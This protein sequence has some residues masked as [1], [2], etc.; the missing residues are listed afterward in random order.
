MDPVLSVLV[1]P[2]HTLY[3]ANSGGAHNQLALLTAMQHKHKIKL[4]LT[5]DNVAEQD[6]DRLREILCH[7]QF[8]QIGYRKQNRLKRLKYS[9]LKKRRKY[10]NL[11]K[12]LLHNDS[13]INRFLIKE[14]SIIYQMAEVIRKEQADVIQIDHTK[15]L[16]LVSHLPGTCKIMYVHHELY[17]TRVYQELTM[18][19]HCPDYAKQIANAVRANELH[20]LRAC[21][22]VVTF[23]ESDKDILQK[24]GLS[25]PVHV[26]KPFCLPGRTAN[27][28]DADGLPKLIF[29]GGEEH[30]PNKEGLAWF[31]EEVYPL[32]SA[33]GKQTEIW[34]TGEWSAPFQKKYQYLPLQ[35]LGFVP[36]LEKVM[37]N[38][39]SLSP[40]R[41]G[42]GVRIKICT[43]IAKGLPVVS[44]TLGASG[45]NGLVNGLNILIADTAEEFAAGI[46]QL[47]EQRDLRK[48]L[49]E[50][51]YALGERLFNGEEFV[52]TRMSFL[53]QIATS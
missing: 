22:G 18:K 23:A 10:S 39:I 32:L 51:A 48:K 26:S 30:Y 12:S 16:P 5:P 43:S 34:V 27:I 7:V 42:S 19:S 53:A 13:H 41:I 4:I 36:D 50:N 1:V 8:I 21:D 3:P 33:S 37:K 20:Y 15:N 31:F 52:Q 9:I 17:F 24:A 2:G 46:E 29:V 47:L 6:L 40:I 35:F 28:Y 45:I 44:T 49:S 14:S 38:A 11:I 25:I